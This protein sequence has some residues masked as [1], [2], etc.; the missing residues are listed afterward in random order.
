MQ[1]NV[2][3]RLPRIAIGVEHRSEAPGRQAALLRDGGGATDDFTDDLVVLDTHLVQRLDV[4]LGNHQH[5]GRG[6]RVD[7]VEGE[8]PLV[9]VDDRC[10]NLAMDDLAEQT[11]RHG[12]RPAKFCPLPSVSYLRRATAVRAMPCKSRLTPTMTSVRSPW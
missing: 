9:L 7:V 2:K 6:L 5:V 4:S 3:D 11:I 1:M 8:H 12:K 10:G